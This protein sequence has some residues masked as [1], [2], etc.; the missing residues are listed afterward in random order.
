MAQNGKIDDDDDDVI[1][2]PSN[3]GYIENKVPR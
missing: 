2:T 1:L 3:D